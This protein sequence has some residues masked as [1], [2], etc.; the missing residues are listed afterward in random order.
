AGLDLSSETQVPHY[1]VS[2]GGKFMAAGSS[3][4]IQLAERSKRTY[5]GSLELGGSNG[6]LSVINELPLEQYLYSVVGG[7]VSSSWPAEALKAQAVAARSYALAQGARF[8]I[9]NVVDTT[10]SQVY[11]GIGTE[12]AS[13]TSAVDATAGEV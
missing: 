5:R 6:S 2:G 11:N 9:A 12:A 7:E 10:L 4:G 13:V 8:D 1:A 3:S